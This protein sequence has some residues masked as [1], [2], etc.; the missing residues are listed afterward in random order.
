M[1]RLLGVASGMPEIARCSDMGKRG[2]GSTIADWPMLMSPILRIEPGT[3]GGGAT[4]APL[5]LAI[6][7]RKETASTLGGGATTE[8]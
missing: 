4:T 7:R 1:A 2:E 8:P 5:G 6:A 3:V